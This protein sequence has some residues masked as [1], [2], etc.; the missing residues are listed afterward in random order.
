MRFIA[1][2]ALVA[3]CPAAIPDDIDCT[4]EARAS[5]QIT[6]VD[7]FG[8]KIPNA[9]LTFRV[10]GGDAQPCEQLGGAGEFVCGWEQAGDITVTATAEGYFVQ[11]A[12]VRVNADECHVITEQLTVTLD[13]IICTDEI[14][15]A[16]IVEPINEAG[17]SLQR[18]RVEA[19]PYGENWTHPEPCMDLGLGQYAC[20]E[21]WTGEVEIWVSDRSAGSWYDVIDVPFD[22]CGPITQTVRPVVDRNPG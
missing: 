20:G 6:V 8:G 9:E 14:V 2:I 7:T 15:Y 4:A 10:D 22:E 12:A 19:M 16:V 18:A 21:G 13:E 3:G 1:L 5:V 11:E 17:E